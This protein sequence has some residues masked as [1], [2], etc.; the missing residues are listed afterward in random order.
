MVEYTLSFDRSILWLHCSCS[1][2][3]FP[4]FFQVRLGPFK[5]ELLGSV[6]ARLLQGWSSKVFLQISVLLFA[7]QHFGDSSKLEDLC[8]YKEC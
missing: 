5:S 4:E 1:W 8:S 2:I 7:K 3:I 6:S